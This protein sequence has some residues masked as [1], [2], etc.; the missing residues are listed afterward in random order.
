MKNRENL[1]KLPFHSIAYF[2]FNHLI[3]LRFPKKEDERD[4]WIDAINKVNDKKFQS[5]GSG[6][7]CN[8]HFASSDFEKV[9]GHFQLKS[10]SV[11]ILDINLPDSTNG[12]QKSIVLDNND[13]PLSNLQCECTNCHKLLSRLKEEEAMRIKSQLNFDI[14]VYEKSDIIDKITKICDDQKEKNFVLKKRIEHL[15]NVRNQLEN[16]VQ[17]LQNKVLDYMNVSEINVIKFYCVL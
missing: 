16:R 12:T 2:F 13:K 17:I 5:K 4:L 10:K 15:E 1:I 8:L 3:F 14:K 7:L 9:K 11:P 6:W